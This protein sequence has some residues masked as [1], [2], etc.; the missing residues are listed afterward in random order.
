MIK[1]STL[2]NL[3]MG[4]LVGKASA[5][6]STDYTHSICSQVGNLLLYHPLDLKL[7]FTVDF[8]RIMHLS[9]HTTP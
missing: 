4:C 8:P 5:C 6:L 2:E 3:D 7:G 1:C 9:R